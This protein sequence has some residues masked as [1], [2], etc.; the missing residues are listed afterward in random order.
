MASWL[1]S[2]SV[3]LLWIC[4]C[5]QDGSSADPVGQTQI[6]LHSTSEEFT[7]AAEAAQIITPPL[8]CW[9]VW[10]VFSDMLCLVLCS[11]NILLFSG[12]TFTF[13][14]S[15][16]QRYWFTMFLLSWSLTFRMLA[17]VW[18]KKM[19]STWEYYRMFD[20]K[21]P[22]NIFITLWLVL[23]PSWIWSLLTEQSSVDKHA[24]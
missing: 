20:F 8:P 13:N 11:W 4:C 1:F 19:F 2:L 16:Q 14:P 21:W 10:A 17:E 6:K 24:S 7:A 23:L 18:T 9:K 15:K 3:S 5:V 12:I 22:Q